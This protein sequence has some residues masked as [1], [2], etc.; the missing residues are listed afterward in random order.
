MD[1]GACRA[2]VHGAAKSQTRLSYNKANMLSNVSILNAMMEHTG[3]TSSFLVQGVMVRM[4]EAGAG[5]HT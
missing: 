3:T 2:T 4:G 5:T 1:R